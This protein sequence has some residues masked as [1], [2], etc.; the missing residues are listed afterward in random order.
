M[1]PINEKT[2]ATI[3]VVIVD[4]EERS[5]TILQQLIEQYC[6]QL[7]VVATAHDVLS[8]VKVIDQWE[9]EVIFLDIEMPNY[10]GFK[11]I[12]HYENIPFKFIF[13][14]AYETYAL[15]AFKM[16]AAG[17]LLKPIDIDE[18]I[19]I[20]EKVMLEIRNEQQNNTINESLKPN[21]QSLSRRIIMPTHNGLIY[22][23][24]NEIC[25][26]KSEGRYT[27]MFLSDGTEMLI[28]LS[29]KGCQKKL[30]NTTLLRVHRSHII[31]LTY[32]KKY[33]RGRD[34]YVLLDNDIRVDVGKNFKDD[35]S[36][37]ISLFLR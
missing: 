5:R 33:A 16:S 36:Q 9:P 29:L 30:E 11:L 31:N 12:E 2:P 3:K 17:Y 20:V 10:S 15:R 14:T 23:N 4:D 18:L 8:A 25:Y 13:T 35:L 21:D 1:P 22:V 24:L 7:E 19:R 6:P 34:A 26:L 37:A 27:C 28:T 32:L